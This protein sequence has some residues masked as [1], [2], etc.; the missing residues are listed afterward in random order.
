[1]NNSIVDFRFYSMPDELAIQH[2]CTHTQY[3][4]VF[5]IKSIDYTD[6]P[7]ACKRCNKTYI[8]EID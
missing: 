6:N 3:I 8:W 4:S 7:L 2:Y 5:N 1:M